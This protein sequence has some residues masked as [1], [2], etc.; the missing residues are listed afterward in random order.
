[1]FFSVIE[2]QPVQKYKTGRYINFVK[3][4]SCT[5]I[6]SFHIFNFNIEICI[7][8]ETIQDIGA[9]K[10][11]TLLYIHPKSF[12]LSIYT[13]RFRHYSHQGIIFISS[14]DNSWYEYNFF[15]QDTLSKSSRLLR[16]MGNQV[17]YIK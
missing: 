4:I 13:P 3:L 2:Y 15:G 11:F 8:V 5:F 14:S 1:M 7:V 17:L 10:L 12:F 16:S 9:I 6:F